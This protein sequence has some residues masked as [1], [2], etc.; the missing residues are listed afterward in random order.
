M[1]FQLSARSEQ[2]L[3]G[4]H[5]DLVKVVRR[6]L[7][8]SKVDFSVSEGLRTYARQKE[9]FEAS[10]S[11][12]MNSRHLS[13]H[14]VDLYPVVK[15]SPGPEWEPV[16]FAEIVD[17]MRRASKALGIPLTHG[18]DWGWDHPHHEL[19]RLAYPA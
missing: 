18:A 13:G 2:R 8:L 5:P 4:V 9:L 3:Q 10:K 15:I 19:Q 1:S 7:E 14:A 16:D 12:T 17:A 11:K 6:A